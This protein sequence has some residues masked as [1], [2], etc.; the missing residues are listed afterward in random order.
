MSWRTSF[1]EHVGPNGLSGTTFGDW[2]RILVENRFAVDARYW[3]RAALITSNSLLNSLYRWCEDLR[4]GGQVKRTEVP[5]PLFILGIWR[6]GTTHLHNLLCKDDRFAFPNTYQVLYPHTFL[7]TEKYGAPIMQ[8]FM[9]ATRVMDNVKGGVDEP[10]EDEFA[11]VASGLSYFVSIIF[12]RGPQL[13]RRYLSLAE[14]TPAER[15]KW[16]SALLEFLQ[17]LT[18]KYQRPLVLK[19]PAHT[20]RIA[21]LLE[22]FPQA[23]FVHIHRNP[24][25]VYQSTLSMWRKVRTWWGLQRCDVDEERV[26]GDYE[27]IYTRYFAERSLIPPG[28]LCEVGF[29]ELERNPLPE[30]ARIYESLGLPDFD[31]V[32]PKLRD[33]LQ[34][35]SEYRRNAY[36]ELPAETRQRIATRWGRFFDEWGYAR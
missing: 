1:I 18:L 27:E 6:S 14:A 32:E 12:P 11:L 3:P 20:C 21:T 34:S 2:C 30:L 7:T 5:P 24:Y 4:W 16:K 22:M 29:D 19:S 13:Y 33:Y 10:Q 25:D 36:R 8:W 28:N 15:Q 35:I 31:H 17:K 23:K 9:P 26:L